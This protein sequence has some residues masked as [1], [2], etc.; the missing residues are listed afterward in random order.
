MASQLKHTVKPSGGDFTSLD[1]CLDH[2][3][4]SHADLVSADVYADVE[5]D[6]TWSSAD[7][8]RCTT[9]GITTDATRYLN[10]YTTA[11]ARHDGKWDTG[12]Y[13]LF[14][15]AETTPIFGNYTNCLYIT[16]LQIKHQIDSPVNCIHLY[17]VSGGTSTAYID[18]C[19]LQ[20]ADNNAQGIE[21]LQYMDTVY[22]TNTIV[23]KPSGTAQAS[24][25]EGIII[26][27][28]TVYIYNCVVFNFNDGIELDGGSATVTNC[29]VFGNGDD[30]DGTMT[31]SYCASDDGDGTNAV[32]ISP[33]ANEATDWANA[34]VDYANGDFHVRDTDS[35]LYSAGTDLSGTFTTDIDGQTR[36]GTWDIGA[37]EY[38]AAG[39]STIWKSQRRKF[40]HLV[41][42]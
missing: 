13:I 11:A 38:V 32:N 22:I 10:I 39:G 31:I 5:I 41:V 15:Y 30:F 23:Y 27:A 1:A 12:A 19:I 26:T 14:V 33:G 34:F 2:L 21:S 29:A 24:N 40:Q 18:K 3:A 6:G 42:R 8:T 36:S 20:C 4:A 9:T 17:G 16:G 7:T 28:G 25:D 37:D 35:V